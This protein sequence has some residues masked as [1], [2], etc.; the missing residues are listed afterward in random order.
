MSATDLDPEIVKIVEDTD[1]E[2]L[3][4]VNDETLE[5]LRSGS[6]PW[7]LSDKVERVGQVIRD[8]PHLSVRIHAKKGSIGTDRPCVYSIHGG[9]YV[10]GSVDLDDA[11]FDRLCQKTDCVGISVTY[12]VAPENPYPVP[13]EDCYD[14]LA[15]VFA[16]SQR[17]GIDPARIGIH[18]VSAGGGLAAALALLIRDRAE[19]RIAY[20][21]LDCP[22]LDDRQITSSSKAENL[23]AWTH[24]SN[25]YGWQSYL[26]DLYGADDVP[27]LA[28]PARADD[29]SGLPLTYIGVGGADGFRD[30]NIKYALRL[31]ECNVPCELHVYPGA[32]HAAVLFPQVDSCARYINDK[33]NWMA[34]QIANAHT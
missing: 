4:D 6:I 7:E 16:N 12:R 29:L 24:A 8:D 20:Q 27:Y 14:G 22:M 13:L 26:G 15:W 34:A 21:A 32:P 9:G 25:R 3:P 10:G 18:G 5:A 19:Y 31:G 28:S 23:V 11:L 30:E 2:W 33:E 1:M 17:L